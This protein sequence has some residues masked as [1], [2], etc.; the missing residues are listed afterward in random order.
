MSI[1]S[2]LITNFFTFSRNEH[3]KLIYSMRNN[4]CF[5]HLKK[6][7]GIKIKISV[8]I[9]GWLVIIFRGVSKNVS[10]QCRRTYNV[11]V[12][13][14]CISFLSV[15]LCFIVWT[16]LNFRSINNFFCPHSSLDPSLIASD[17]N[18][19]AVSPPSLNSIKFCTHMKDSSDHSIK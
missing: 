14:C 8:V 7:T 10:I 1:I 12:I 11:N 17:F 6:T 16:L 4:A 18:F 5:C 3:A 19:L 2:N 15:V 9:D 13:D